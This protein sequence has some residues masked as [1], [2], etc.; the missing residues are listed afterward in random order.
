MQNVQPKLAADG[1]KFNHFSHATYMR[2]YVSR[3]GM[4][5]EIRHYS[6]IATDITRNITR[7]DNKNLSRCEKCMDRTVPKV[8]RCA[9]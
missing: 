3:S 8:S 6:D 1:C 2:A 5:Q 4:M 7:A 9:P